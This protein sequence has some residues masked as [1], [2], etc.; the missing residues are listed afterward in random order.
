MSVWRRS[1][2]VTG[3]VGLAVLPLAGLDTAAA[4]SPSKTETAETGGMSAADT[5]FMQEAATGGIP[6]AELGRL[7]ADKASSPDVKQFGQRMVDD[8]SKA[9]DE[10]KSLASQKGVTLP[11]SPDAAQKAMQVRLSKLS[12]AE[13]DR[14]YMQDMVKDHDKDVAAF[15]HASMTAADADLKAWAAKTL[16]TLEEHQQQAKSISAKLHPTG[17]SKAPAKKDK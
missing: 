17:A 11:A 12:T 6:E 14:A 4:K 8:H 5:K 10:L 15:K 7:A 16:P 3:V 13:F 2:I 1:V 9:N